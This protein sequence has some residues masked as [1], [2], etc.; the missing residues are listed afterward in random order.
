MTLLKK[1][2]LLIALVLTCAVA[3]ALHTLYFKPLSLNWFYQKSSILGVLKYPE[4]LSR[5]H[6]L[7]NYGLA[8][9]RSKLRSEERRVGKECRL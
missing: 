9:Y 8:F 6:L 7:D 3:L 5:L 2:F 4:F 1:I